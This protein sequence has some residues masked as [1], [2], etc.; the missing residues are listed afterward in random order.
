[1][2]KKGGGGEYFWVFPCCNYLYLYNITTCNAAHDNYNMEI[3]SIYKLETLTMFSPYSAHDIY[4][5]KRML[6]SILGSIFEQKMD[7]LTG[8]SEQ[9]SRRPTK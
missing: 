5:S 7:E 3:I 8:K 4:I 2:G 6:N 9:D 1:M